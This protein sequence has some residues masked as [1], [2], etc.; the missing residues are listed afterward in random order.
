[1]S[2]DKKPDIVWETKA[3]DELT[4]LELHDLLRVRLDIFVVEQNC[5]Y[6]EIDGMDPLCTHVIGKTDEGK[7]IATAR[8]APAGT[9]YDECSIGRVVVK[10]EYRQFKIGKELMDVSILYCKEQKGVK[11]I[12]IAAQLYLRKFYSSFGFEQISD[13]YP[14]DGIDHIDMRLTFPG[15]K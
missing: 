13:V 8:I 5:P 11:T 6:S 1:M 3:F 4:L 14:W 12:K 7:L 9:I 15:S 10:E 2:D